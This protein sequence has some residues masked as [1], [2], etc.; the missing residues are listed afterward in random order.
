MKS[1]AF[2]VRWFL[3]SGVLVMASYALA[4]V[5]EQAR[6]YNEHWEEKFSGFETVH[7]QQQILATLIESQRKW[8]D[9]AAFNLFELQVTHQDLI[10]AEKQLKTTQHEFYHFMRTL[11]NID[12]EAYKATVDSIKKPKNI[13]PFFIPFPLNQDCEDGQCQANSSN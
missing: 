12:P 11:E 4:Q 2:L 3:Y 1:I 8:E 10:V 9:Q 7:E 13:I 6:I 5:G